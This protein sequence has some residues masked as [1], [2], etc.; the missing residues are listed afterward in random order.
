MGRHALLRATLHSFPS[1][2]V[3]RSFHMENLCI[4]Y[5]AQPELRCDRTLQ[6]SEGRPNC[7]SASAHEE[8]KENQADLTTF[9]HFYWRQ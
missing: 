8:E 7:S 2:A 1:A 9:L 6:C 5:P 4:W 3:R